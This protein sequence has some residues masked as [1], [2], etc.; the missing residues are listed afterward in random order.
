MTINKSIEKQARLLASEQ[1]KADPTIKKVYWFPHGA[2]VRL[3]AV[4]NQTTIAEDGGIDPFYFR[5]SASDSLPSPSAIAL[6][7]PEESQKLAPPTGW[8]NWSDA[9]EL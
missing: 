7:R 3:I 8:G 9:I 1:R 6:I 2:E 4:S 5:A